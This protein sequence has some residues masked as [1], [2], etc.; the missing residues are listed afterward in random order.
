MWYRRWRHAI[1]YAAFCS[2]GAY[3]MVRIL[4]QSSALRK[5]ILIV[6]A[7]LS[8]TD[9]LRFPVKSSRGIS[10]VVPTADPPLTKLL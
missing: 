9:G 1:S 3:A 6:P 4:D 10:L 7:T 5:L 2:R 8:Y